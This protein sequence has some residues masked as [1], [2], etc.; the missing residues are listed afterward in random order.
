M[1]SSFIFALYEGTF[2]MFLVIE[3]VLFL[4]FSNSWKCFRRTV[5]INYSTYT[6]GHIAYALTRPS[7]THPRISKY[8]MKVEE[9]ED[10]NLKDGPYWIVTGIRTDG[11]TLVAI[12]SCF[13]TMYYILIK[14]TYAC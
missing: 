6:H 11:R 14:P 4:S 10:L 8:G 12:H 9:A 13:S 3:S 1:L 5:K 2:I 7:I